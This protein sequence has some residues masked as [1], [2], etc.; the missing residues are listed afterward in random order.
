[1]TCLDGY[2][3]AQ[4]GRAGPALAISAIGSFIAGSIAIIGLVLICPP[5][6]QAALAFGPPN[7][8]P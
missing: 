1:M 3:M 2:Q 7:I 5:L 4:K 8:S 6:A